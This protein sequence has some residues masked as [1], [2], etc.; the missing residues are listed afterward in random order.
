MDMSEYV[1]INNFAKSHGVPRQAVLNAIEL[2][3]LKTADLKIDGEHVIPAS[4][5]DYKFDLIGIYEYAERK[6]VT[7][8]AIYKRIDNG[9]MLYSLE[10]LSDVMKID[11]ELYKDEKFRSFAFKHRGKKAANQF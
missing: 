10:E 9:K 8:N 2:N 4:L 11:W 6:Q 5:V 1:S 7:F 3:K